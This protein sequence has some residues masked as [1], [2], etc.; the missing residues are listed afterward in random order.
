[1]G[2]ERNVY[3][4]GLKEAFTIAANYSTSSARYERGLRVCNWL[5]LSREGLDSV[6]ALARYN[7]RWYVEPAQALMKSLE[8]RPLA[9][10]APSGFKAGSVS[11]LRDKN[12]FILAVR[13]VNFTLLENGAYDLHGD[14]SF[15]SRILLLN[16]DRDFAVTSAAEVHEPENMPVPQHDKYRGFEDPRLFQW[17]DDLWCVCSVC[18]L[19]TDG[20]SQMI[21]ARID[22]S[23]PDRFAFND[24]RVLVS[25]VTPRWE[26]NW[27]PQ[28]IGDEL[29]FVYSL[30]PMRI[31]TEAG[32]IVHH[33]VPA[34]AAENFKGGSQVVPFD[35]GWLML[36]HE[37][38]PVG[39]WRQ[40]LH[41]FVWLD[42]QY[43]LRRV[44]RRF[45]FKQVACEFASGLAWH[46]DEERLVISFAVDER[47]PHLASVEAD[48]V[49]A[50]LLDVDAHRRESEESVAM[51][52]PFWRAL[53]GQGVPAPCSEVPPPSA[54]HPLL[55]PRNESPVTNQLLGYSS[56]D[57]LEDPARA[58]WV[59]AQTNRAL[60]DH[61]AL[62]EALAASVAAGLP[63]HTDAPKAWDN[64]LAI[65]HTAATTEPDVPVLDAGA[66]RQSAYLP[67]LRKLG[68]SESHRDKPLGARS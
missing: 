32:K 26:K 28:V 14:T 43:Q 59:T 60:R 53:G 25:G 2:L 37:W 65:F 3:E 8:L 49:R 22:R 6:R 64:F 40:Y 11:V 23:V 66:G 9:I 46:V 38:E 61:Q 24:W 67:G 4:S 27:M 16:L 50:V 1:M 17:R 35:G 13:A 7:L 56:S 5:A 51:G 19:S 45:F 57:I 39:G 12:G 47:E 42:D 52:R 30:D 48:D 29:R 10:D 36:I 41:R 33:E 44:S 31:I 58:V 34:I 21:L 15:R 20:R 62:D 55:H 68:F 63:L 18:E 54:R